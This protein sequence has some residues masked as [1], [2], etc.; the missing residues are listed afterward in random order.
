MLATVILLAISRLVLWPYVAAVVAFVVASATTWPDVTKAR[1]SEKIVALNRL[2]IAVP[3][4]IFGTEHLGAANFIAPQ[5]PA[6]IPWHLFWAYFVGLALLAASLSIAARVLTRWSGTLLGLM[7]LIFVLTIH[8]PR[9]MANPHDRFAW[10]VAVRDLSFAG[11]AWALSRTRL[12]PG[13]GPGGHPLITLGRII[14]SAVAI[15][16][17]VEHF[18]HPQHLP[19]VPLEK[20]T[21]EWIPARLAIG[22]LTGAFLLIAG[23]LILIGRKARTAATYLGAEI[24]VLVVFIY[25]PLLFAVASDPNLG[26]KIEGMNYFGDTLL[27]SGCI[28]AL[29]NA[30]PKDE[31]LA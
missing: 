15:F 29:A 9:V 2:F 31:R 23:V 5:I 21:P 26:V 6:W 16:F 24:S 11:G 4:A 14:I 20:L 10:A 1:G 22:Y 3:L 28:L 30:L 19:G 17:A 27:Y 12:S 7:I 13:R 25:V 18:M 8:I